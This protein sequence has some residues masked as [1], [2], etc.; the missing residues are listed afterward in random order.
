LKIAGIGFLLVAIGLFVIPHDSS[1]A[2]MIS[3]A[4]HS[5]EEGHTSTLTGFTMIL[6]GLVLGI[7]GALVGGRDS[8]PAGSS[9]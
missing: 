4:M 2:N 6:F 1:P 7:V 3:Q 5:G 8:N 9:A